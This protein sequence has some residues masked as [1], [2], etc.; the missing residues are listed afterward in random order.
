MGLLASVDWIGL[1]ST[2]TAYTVICR[3]RVSSAGER[4]TTSVGLQT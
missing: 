1:E 2:C 4:V 3:V